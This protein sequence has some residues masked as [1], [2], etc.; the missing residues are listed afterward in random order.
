MVIELVLLVVIT[1]VDIGCWWEARRSS[2][3]M[4]L[5]FDERK[6]WYAARAKYPTKNVQSM[7]DTQTSERVLQKPVE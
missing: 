5:Y 7:P 1:L 4:R 3:V 2:N 6:R